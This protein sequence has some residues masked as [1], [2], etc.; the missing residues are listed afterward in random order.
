MGFVPTANGKS[1]LEIL[2]GAQTGQIQ[3]VYLLG[4]DEIDMNKL[5]HAFVIYQGHHGDK[6]AARADVILPG[7][8]YTEKDAL[9]TNTE[10]R[11]QAARRAVFPPGAAQE[12]W[13]II[14]ALSEVLGQVLPF[15]NLSQ[16]RQKLVQAHPIFA[17][18]DCIEPAPWNV[19]GRDGVLDALPLV[20]PIKNFYHTDVISRA[21]P[22]MA[23]CVDE[24]LRPMMEAAE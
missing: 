13:K 6:G 5:G 12:D 11:I 19:F 15:D 3:M 8:A 4:A 7:C 23:K 18:L 21:S 17:K 2:H 24:I 20:S 22:T 1:T 14:R 16:L 10:G 9:Y